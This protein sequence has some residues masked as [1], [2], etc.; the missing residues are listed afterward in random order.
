MY[1]IELLCLHSENPALY[2]Q[3]LTDLRLNLVTFA[4]STRPKPTSY[5]F[6]SARPPTIGKYQ[7]SKMLLGRYKLDAQKTV[8]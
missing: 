1:H 3:K 5:E 2:Q 6:I 8:G 7:L 4:P